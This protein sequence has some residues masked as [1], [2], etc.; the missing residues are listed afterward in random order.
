MAEAAPADM[1][2]LLRIESTEIR[3][4]DAA[5]GRLRIVGLT[6]A[7]S[8]AI[9]GLRAVEL[10]VTSPAH[11][12]T[13]RPVASEP[14]RGDLF[15]RTGQVLA[16]TLQ[17]YSLFADPTLVWDAS[18]AAQSLSTVLPD[19]D[20]EA[21]TRELSSHRRF[22]WIQRN[23]TPRQRQAVF[24][25][26]L[27][28]LDFRIEPRRIYPRGRLAAHV[29]GYTDRDMNGLAGAERSFDAA[30]SS[31]DG[32][33]VALSIDMGVQFHLDEVLRTTMA[34]YRALAASGI[35]M[36]VRTGEIV[37]MVSLP[38]FDPN[39]PN[40]ASSDERLNRSA[41]S[42]YEMGS[43]FKAFTVA[44]ALE[45]GTA[46]L[47]S[48]YDATEPLQIGGY[49]IHDYH[50]ENR[51]LTLSEIFIH[52][53]NIGSSRIA[54]EV[55]AEAQREF[56]GRMRL[57]ERAPIELAESADP[58]LP[59]NW[60][61]T[62]TATISYGHGLAVSPI[63]TIAA[64]AA[65]ANGGI[66]VA[67]TLQPVAADETIVGERV[68]DAQAAQDVMTLMRE[69]VTDGTGGR[70]EAPGYL[71]AGKTGTAEKPSRGGYDRNRLISSFS[72]VFPY[73]DPQYAI[74][75]LLDEPQGTAAT[76]G[77]ATGGWTAAPAVSAIVSRIAPILG[78][79][80]SNADH[81]ERA[82]MVR[83]ALMPEPIP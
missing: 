54:L 11:A 44:M 15:D 28:G 2:R 21:V 59:R 61:P 7:L 50:G 27:P 31:S 77:Y 74:L 38:D 24:S 75:V 63:A 66:Y 33:P 1:S 4:L 72:A 76:H 23:L 25:L 8:F 40:D 18:E 79:E 13:P 39:R 71:V 3:A 5:R 58:L 10:A 55:G 68:L 56:L 83:A 70:A 43:T 62:E 65:I 46:T 80:R 47:E 42:V 16:T 69:N 12:A 9:L 37:G 41:Q 45:A 73:N 20:V 19:L 34:E 22:V 17:T 26:G 30:L 82:A 67:P 35:V 6:L 64:F 78:V 49:T 60:G 14:M 51:W 53:S 81:S 57:L 29:V 32:R 52:S 48:G 36:N